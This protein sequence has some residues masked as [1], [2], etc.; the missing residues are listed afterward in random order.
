MDFKWNKE[1]KK[2]EGV[3]NQRATTG[4]MELV[5]EAPGQRPHILKSHRMTI[6]YQGPSTIVETHFGPGEDASNL[7]LVF[8][9]PL[10][11]DTAYL[12][13][14]PFVGEDADVFASF[15]YVDKGGGTGSGIGGG[16]LQVND[17]FQNGQRLSI[18][19]RFRFHYNVPD[20]TV[21]VNCESF[22]L[23]HTQ[24]E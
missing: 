10:A 12:I 18:E 3:E 2:I 11:A 7:S 13:G 8:I 9:K 20:G 4:S 5:V 6:G 1:T 22:N 23:E 16:L 15:N 24:D 21:S 19:G 14:N 17:Y